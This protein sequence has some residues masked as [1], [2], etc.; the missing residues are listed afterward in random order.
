MHDR[1]AELAAALRDS[2]LDG[3]GSLDPALRRT[4]AGGG[5]SPA[6][7][8]EYVRTLREHASRMRDEDIA[9]VIAA[10]YTEDQVYEAT[11]ATALGT[12][13]YRL[14]AGLRALA[15]SLAEAP[16]VTAPVVPEPPVEAVAPAVDAGWTPTRVEGAAPLPRRTDG[17]VS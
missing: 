5:P 8:A 14:E 1:H 10:G 15:E 16:E 3:P 13:T 6:A 2:V 17:T 11:I 4:L 7:L 12:G 9:A